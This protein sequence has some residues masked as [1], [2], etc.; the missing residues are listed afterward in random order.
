MEEQNEQQLSKYSSG[1]NINLRLDQLWKDSHLHSRSGKF[2]LWNLDL[3]CVWSELA[4]DLKEK[5]TDQEKQFKE[6]EKKFKTFD[7]SLKKTGNIKDKKPEGF[8][9]PTK[10]ETDNRN[11]QYEILRSKQIFLARLENKLGKG[12]T[13]EDDDDDDM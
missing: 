5:D 2:Y 6:I 13:Y 7:E 3:D 12:T 11:K 4:R 8:E 10:T 9:E 1:V